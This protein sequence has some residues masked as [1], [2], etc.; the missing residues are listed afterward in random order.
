[1]EKGHAKLKLPSFL[2][3]TDT[4]VFCQIAA[5]FL[6]AYSQQLHLPHHTPSTHDS[7]TTSICKAR[8]EECCMRLCA[9]LGLSQTFLR[10]ELSL[11]PR[12]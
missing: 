10:P 1:M 8:S 2:A 4:R 6:N 9:Y 7:G 3:S 11:N 12:A 5:R